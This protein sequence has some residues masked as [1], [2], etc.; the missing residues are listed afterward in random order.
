LS[1]LETL[2]FFFKVFISTFRSKIKALLSTSLKGN[3]QGTSPNGIFLSRGGGENRNIF[4]DLFN[5][6]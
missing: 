1:Q 3:L 6:N 2:I 5:M 4:E